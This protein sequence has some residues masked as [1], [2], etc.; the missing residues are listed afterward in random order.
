MRGVVRKSRSLSTAPPAASRQGFVG[1]ATGI[2]RGGITVRLSM[3]FRAVARGR[4][5]SIRRSMELS[6]PCFGRLW[7]RPSVEAHLGRKAFPRRF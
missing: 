4:S 3:G 7:A 2:P 5:C 1:S 6:P